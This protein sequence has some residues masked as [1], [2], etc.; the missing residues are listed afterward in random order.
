MNA[1]QPKFT[2][3]DVVRVLESA[4]SELR[5]GNI[6]WIIAVFTDRPTGD[7]FSGFPAG[8]VYTIEFEDGFSTDI[9]ESMLTLHEANG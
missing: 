2:Y 1:D 3:D 9:H 7:Y 4:P 6:A 5:P 8:T